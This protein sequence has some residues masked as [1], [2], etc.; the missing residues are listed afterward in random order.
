[1]K[2]RDLFEIY[3]V[4]EQLKDIEAGFKFSYGVAKNLSI[5]RSEI[6][7]FTELAKKRP[8]QFEDYEQ[9]RIELC[10]LYADK[11]GDG[12]PITIKRGQISD[13]MITKNLPEFEEKVMELRNEFTDMHLQIEKHE[14]ELNEMLDSEFDGKVYLINIDDFPE[15]GIKPAFMEILFPIMKEKEDID[16]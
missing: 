4:L 14:K 1:M 3:R 5:I 7:I 6:E 2:K 8:D 11:D 10:K 13:F 15:K 12:N 9:Q 16:K